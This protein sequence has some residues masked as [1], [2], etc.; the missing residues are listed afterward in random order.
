MPPPQT[1]GGVRPGAPRAHPLL[2]GRFG[3]IFVSHQNKTSARPLPQDRAGAGEGAQAQEQVTARLSLRAPRLAGLRTRLR[4]RACVSDGGGGWRGR[5]VLPR[6]PRSWG[7]GDSP[8]CSETPAH[9]PSGYCLS[10]GQVESK[11]NQNGKT[12]NTT[13]RS[14]SR[15]RAARPRGRT[16]TYCICQVF[17]SYR[18]PAVHCWKTEPP[19]TQRAQGLG[20][21]GGVAGRGAGRHSTLSQG[22][23][24]RRG[25][26]RRGRGRGRQVSTGCGRQVQRRGRGWR[27]G[28]AALRLRCELSFFCSFF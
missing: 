15:R 12:R 5:P 18:T 21:A 11:G 2:P 24:S 28:A 9:P 26:L 14:R 1:H 17:A 4:A 8:G 19:P 7:G 6:G 23:T 27:A 25:R 22:V 3:K 13:V 20:Q 16:D 10:F